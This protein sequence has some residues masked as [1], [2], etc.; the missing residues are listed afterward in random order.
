M[1]FLKFDPDTI[2]LEDQFSRDVRNIGRYGTGDLEL[3]IYTDEDF[4]KAKR[5]IRISYDVS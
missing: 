2:T 1:F 4:E 3:T 5:F